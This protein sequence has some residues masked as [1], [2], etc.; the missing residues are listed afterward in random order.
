[1]TCSTVGKMELYNVFFLLMTIE[2]TE[3]SFREHLVVLR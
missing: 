1:M 2:Y 3:A